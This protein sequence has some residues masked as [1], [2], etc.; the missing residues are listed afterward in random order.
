MLLAC[1]WH[2]VNLLRH[3]GLPLHRD[4]RPLALWNRDCTDYPYGSHPFLLEVRP[5][6]SL[7]LSLDLH[8][9]ADLAC[10]HSVVP[11]Q[12]GARM[13]CC[14]GTATRWMQC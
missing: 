7:L 11:T 1:R 14:C 2:A 4:G 5:G 6:T 9:V 3:A 13:A 10:A 8:V 12:T